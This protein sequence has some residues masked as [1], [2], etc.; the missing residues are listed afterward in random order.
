MSGFLFGW[1]HPS[2]RRVI[3]VRMRGISREA[4]RKLLTPGGVLLGVLLVGLLVAPL[5][6]RWL[7][8]G[9]ASTEALRTWGTT[10]LLGL[11]L[12]QVLMRG[13]G[14]VLGFEPA[15]ADQLF[16]APLP[17]EHLLRY[18]LGLLLI[19]WTNGGILL[20]PLASMYGGTVLGGFFAALLVMPFLQMS[21]MVMALIQQGRG[22]PPWVRFVALGGLVM[23]PAAL[24]GGVG[25]GLESVAEG[26]NGLA[27]HPVGAVALAPFVAG[28]TLLA[29]TSTSEILRSAA[30]LLVVDAALAAGM[31]HLGKRSW[32]AKAQTGAD[33][34]RSRFQSYRSG[35][36][37][38]ASGWW[39][40]R[41]PRLPRLGG[42]GTLF[43]RRTVELVRS[44]ATWMGLG[45]VVVLLVTLGLVMGRDRVGVNA[46][47]FAGLAWSTILLPSVLRSDFRADLDRMDALR[48][49]PV[50]NAGLFWG[51]VLP[52]ALLI[53]LFEVGM[54]FA[55]MLY[56]PQI[57]LEGLAVMA[58]APVWTVLVVT[59]ENT[60]FLFVPARME[61][62]EA[63]IG[64]VGRNLLSTFLGWVTHGTATGVA[65]GVAVAVGFV[66]GWGAGVLAFFGGLVVLVV[67]ISLVGIW[68]LARFVPPLT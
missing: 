21:A 17:H 34:L 64:S 25:T 50:S 35:G 18:K 62:G 53:G 67:A 6:L 29:S 54:A 5:V 3:V 36:L 9:L 16:A 51:N 38:S 59:S 24:A 55:L 45:G 39:G 32:L 44:P 31:L 58:I 19:A 26:V 57:A 33:T 15:E 27:A 47:M 41:V 12:V 63:A 68:K 61:A 46:L 56:Q 10:G 1:I 22:V 66:V 48:A 30:V 14:D 23:V 8:P 20:T 60:I 49:M 2:L 11:W 40:V 28:A 65:A 43:W 7:F 4:L 42:W 52:M 37:A 13:G